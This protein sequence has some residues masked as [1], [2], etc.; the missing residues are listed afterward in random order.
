M[1]INENELWLL[2]FY[3]TSEITGAEFFARLAK[4]IKP[5]F[6][7]H[8]LTK[9]FADES[10]HAWYWQKCIHDVGA[11]PLRIDIAYQDRY[12]EAAGLPAN[13][14]EVLAITQVFEKRVIGQ[15]SIHLQT[16]DLHPAIKDTLNLIMED[17]KWHIQWVGDA[18]KKLEP[19][20]GKENIEE[21]LK[22]FRAADQEVYQKVLEEQKDRIH[23]V[24]KRKITYE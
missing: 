3:R 24:L 17:E 20:F 12:I 5:S 7:Q 19:K 6:I 16:P 23:D 21:T 1:K 2:S 11:D 9:H 8:D 18:L 15:Y 13:V 4:Y 22:R 14:M 10:Q